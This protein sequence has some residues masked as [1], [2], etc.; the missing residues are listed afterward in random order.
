MTQYPLPNVSFDLTGQ[1]ALV[2]G[3]SSG[4]GWRVAEVLAATG[5][6]VVASGIRISTSALEA[7]GERM[8]RIVGVHDAIRHAVQ[9]A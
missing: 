9:H 2:T 6:T 3:A 7:L 5:A 4:L 8:V 1:V